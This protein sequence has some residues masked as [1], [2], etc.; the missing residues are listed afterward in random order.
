MAVTQDDL[1]SVIRE[2]LAEEL[3]A[4]QG[5]AGAPTPGDRKEEVSIDTDE[6]LGGGGFAA[7]FCFL[8]A[9][10]RRF[11]GAAPCNRAPDLCRLTCKIGSPR[12]AR[13]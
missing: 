10:P 9:P 12:P 4:I 3:A 11:D 6:A 1:R 7:R 2:L 13:A 5:D 8:D